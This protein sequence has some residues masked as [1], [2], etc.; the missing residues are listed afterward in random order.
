MVSV[1]GMNMAFF[2]D[3]AEKNQVVVHSARAMKRIQPGDEGRSCE[4]HS[5]KKANQFLNEQC[6]HW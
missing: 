5:K 6:H 4:N 2:C 3:K 1:G